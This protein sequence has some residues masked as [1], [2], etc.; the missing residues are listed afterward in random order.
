MGF[1]EPG[2]CMN[3]A[4]CKETLIGLARHA[5][6]DCLPGYNGIKCENRI[7]LNLIYRM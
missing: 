2:L 5:Y 1:C 3:S 4:P 7:D 6:C